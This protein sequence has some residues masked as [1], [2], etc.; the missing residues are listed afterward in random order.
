MAPRRGPKGHRVTHQLV[1]VVDVG[2]ALTGAMR[3]LYH[4]SCQY[5]DP[6]ARIASLLSV[7][8]YAEALMR[9]VHVDFR[10]ACEDAELE[11]DLVL[12]RTPQSV[13]DT[14]EEFFDDFVMDHTP[15]APRVF[16]F[17]QPG[18]GDA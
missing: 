16:T 6:M 5:Q 13:V 10:E 11:D 8:L 17:P 3:Q 14:V 9:Q 18:W 7:Y 4:Y 1:N 15:P 2:Q 12:Q